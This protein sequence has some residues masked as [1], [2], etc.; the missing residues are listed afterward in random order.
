MP[1]HIS[2]KMTTKTAR[3][4]DSPNDT[5][6]YGMNHMSSPVATCSS[7]RLLRRPPTSRHHHSCTDH[8]SRSLNDTPSPEYNNSLLPS[9]PR[10]SSPEYSPYSSLIIRTVLP[11]SSS[12]RPLSTQPP[13]TPDG[14][15]HPITLP[16]VKEN[17]P[18]TSTTVDIRDSLRPPC[19]S[20]D[21]SQDSSPYIVTLRDKPD[22]SLNSFP[23]NMIL[24][25]RYLPW[26]IHISPNSVRDVVVALYTALRTRVTNEEMKVVGGEDVM[27]TFA[28][29]VE[30][31][32]EEERRKGVRRVDFLL[33]YTRF[34][35]IEPST[36]EPGVWKICLTP[37]S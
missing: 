36:D 11:L 35:G 13:P 16:P 32:G 12:S 23:T 22:V 3:F 21:L 30:R 20:I 25:S 19:L 18:E 34:V 29:R 17:F 27:N 14:L 5:Y 28:K 2:T 15:R 8:H 10:F 9:L 26:Q 1:H 37:M 4:A 33:G 24:V 7:Q 6:S 31:A